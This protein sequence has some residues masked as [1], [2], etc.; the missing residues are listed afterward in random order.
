MKNT[1]KD[2]IIKQCLDIFSIENDILKVKIV[3]PLVHYFKQ[4]L[5]GF[6]LVITIILCFILITNI[7]IIYK[8]F[9]LFNSI[10]HIRDVISLVK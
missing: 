6:Y 8:L 3:D 2:S 1:I 9:Y 4:K 7:F 5:S 10:L